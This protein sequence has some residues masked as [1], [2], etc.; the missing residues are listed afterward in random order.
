MTGREATTS[1]TRRFLNYSWQPRDKGRVVAQKR[2]VFFY[3]YLSHSYNFSPRLSSLII[4][5]SLS[6]DVRVCLTAISSSTFPWKL[7]GFSSCFSSLLISSRLLPSKCVGQFACVLRVLKKILNEL[8]WC[9][10]IF[11]F[12]PLYVL[13]IY[14]FIYSTRCYLKYPFKFK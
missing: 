10:S 11:I 8:L 13:Q 5:L 4:Y 12:F 7:L 3:F 14:I 1:G 6:R 2:R 9:L